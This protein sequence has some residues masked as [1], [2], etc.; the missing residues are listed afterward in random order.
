MKNNNL[1]NLTELELSS[2]NAGGFW[3]TLG[4]YVGKGLAY[5]AHGLSATSTSTQTRWVYENSK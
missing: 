4:E 5:A 3:Y 1:S 2:I